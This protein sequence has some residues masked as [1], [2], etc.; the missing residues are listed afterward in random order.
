MIPWYIV[1]NPLRLAHLET[2]TD[3]LRDYVCPRWFR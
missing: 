3:P 1:L 2:Y